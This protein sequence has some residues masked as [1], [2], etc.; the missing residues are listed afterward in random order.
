MHE[1]DALEMNV[2][3]A[4]AAEFEHYMKRCHVNM[5]LDNTLRGRCP[6]TPYELN[7]IQRKS[8]NIKANTLKSGFL[9]CKSEFKTRGARLRAMVERNLTEF[10]TASTERR[11]GEKKN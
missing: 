2:N 5:T 1:C 8:P 9:M 3:S 10:T 4:G 11:R 6:A 7:K